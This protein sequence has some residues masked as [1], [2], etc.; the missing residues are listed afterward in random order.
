MRKEQ[1]QNSVEVTANVQTTPATSRNADPITREQ[2]GGIL[3]IPA[4]QRM[5]RVKNVGPERGGLPVIMQIN[6]GDLGIGATYPFDVSFD[7]VN[8]QEVLSPI[9][10]INTNGGTAWCQYY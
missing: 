6:G 4:G 1:K 3:I 7:R 10:T 9:L 2:V 5:V 8:N